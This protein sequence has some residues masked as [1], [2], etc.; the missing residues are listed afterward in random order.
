MVR[1]HRKRER[2]PWVAIFGWPLI[3]ATMAAVALVRTGDPRLDPLLRLGFG[4]PALAALLW[5][6][7]K[8]SDTRR[9]R[10]HILAV[11]LVAGM[12]FVG[13]FL[14]FFT[15]IGGEQEATATRPTTRPV[16][17]PPA[18]PPAAPLSAAP[19]PARHTAPAN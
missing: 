11:L 18:S 15:T 2:V 4:V 9:Y 12:T 13:L 6:F 7:A 16:H 5:A 8:V 19:E 3:G 14:Y 17:T 1:S 10:L